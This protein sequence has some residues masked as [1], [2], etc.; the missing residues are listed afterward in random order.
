MSSSTTATS[1]GE[2]D[3]TAQVSMLFSAIGS[4][5]HLTHLTLTGSED[6]EAFPVVALIQLL[7][8]TRWR[9]QDHSLALL[10]CQYVDW[11]A[12]S[13]QQMEELGE[14]FRHCQIQKIQLLSLKVLVGT[15]PAV[16]LDPLVAALGH[17]Q[18]VELSM[19]HA[20]AST[21]KSG[22]ISSRALESLLK[23]TSHLQ[24]LNL[25]RRVSLTC[26][27]FSTI[28]H[29]LE[30]DNYCQLRQLQLDHVVVN[31]C[32]VQPLAAA[33]QNPKTRLQALDVTFS[34]PW[35][36]LAAVHAVTEALKHNTVLQKLCLRG[37]IILNHEKDDDQRHYLAF[38]DLLQNHN[39][40][41]E[42]LILV[43]PE[44]V[45]VGSTTTTSGYAFRK[46][47]FFLHLNRQ[48]VRDNLTCGLRTLVRQQN[49]AIPQHLMLPCLEAARKVDETLD[50]LNRLESSRDNDD[51]DDDEEETD[52]Y[53]YVY[54]SS[55]HPQQH[56]QQQHHQQQQRQNKDSINTGGCSALFYLLQ[57]QPSLVLSLAHALEM[58]QVQRTRAGESLSTAAGATC[59]QLLLLDDDI[60]TLW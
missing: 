60:V 33:L 29:C 59:P 11:M 45:A 38:L 54:H 6:A 37:A 56:Q 10:S 14:A 42:E 57:R 46:L 16:T 47:Q 58:A 19:R 49:E 40:T 34:H 5:P 18:H 48:P 28:L 43:H 8:A 39:T 3:Y 20:P 36:D 9:H 12:D 35:M 15:R 51:D 31:A 13:G 52:F 44:E 55:W 32:H 24:T 23:K 53:G 2:F 7:R 27:E 22:Y 41:L 21:Q 30:D 17:C 25:G 1:T 50:A 26:H 4:L